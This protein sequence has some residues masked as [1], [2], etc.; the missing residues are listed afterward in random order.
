MLY[1]VWWLELWYRSKHE[2]HNH[3]AVT[4]SNAVAWV[5]VQISSSMKTCIRFSYVWIGDANKFKASNCHCFAVHMWP[6]QWKWGCTV[7]AILCVTFLTVQKL[8]GLSLGKTTWIDLSKSYGLFALRLGS[9][10]NYFKLV[11]DRSLPLTHHLFLV[12]ILC[13]AHLLCRTKA[14]KYYEIKWFAGWTSQLKYCFW[15]W[16][17]R[18]RS[19]GWKILRW[20]L[21]FP[22]LIAI[23]LHVNIM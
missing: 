13:S 18:R 22:A 8:R 10:Y 19:H 12:I 17:S 3:G 14:Y 11:V 15:P 20:S 9:L 1:R 21:F 16:A 2:A 4:P 5:I 7:I 23:R 6:P